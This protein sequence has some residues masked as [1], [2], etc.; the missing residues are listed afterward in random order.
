MP[1]KKVGPTD[2][3][4][5]PTI[6]W[7]PGFCAVEGSD[8]G[9]YAIPDTSPKKISLPTPSK[10]RV[11]VF[12]ASSQI[13]VPEE[14]KLKAAK[15]IPLSKSARKRL[16]KLGDEWAGEGTNLENGFEI[17]KKKPFFGKAEYH[18]G[19]QL[20]SNKRE[21]IAS[22]NKETLDDA[23]KAV[24]IYYD[25][26]AIK[27]QLEAQE[28]RDTDSIT[29]E[30]IKVWIG[31]LMHK[32]V[33][34]ER[35]ISPGLKSDYGEESDQEIIQIIAPLVLIRF[36]GRQNFIMTKK[37][38]EELRED[39][40]RANF[41]PI[42]LNYACDLRRGTSNHDFFFDEEGKIQN[43][44]KLREMFAA[45]VTMQ[46][47]VA[48]SN[49][50]GCVIEE[51]AEFFAGLGERTIQQLKEIFYEVAL[52]SISQFHEPEKK[53]GLIV[54]KSSVAKQQEEA[55]KMD[56]QK[57]VLVV[58]NDCDSPQKF[59]YSAVAQ[60]TMEEFDTGIGERFSN[61]ETSKAGDLLLK[62][63]MMRALIRPGK[64]M[65]SIEN[66]S[67]EIEFADISKVNIPPHRRTRMS[68]PTTSPTPSARN[69]LG[70]FEEEHDVLETKAMPQARDIAYLSA[71]D[72]TGQPG[73]NSASSIYD[74]PSYESKPRRPVVSATNKQG[75]SLYE[76]ASSGPASKPSSWQTEKSSHPS[77]DIILTKYSQV[78]QSRREHIS[79]FATKHGNRFVAIDSLNPTSEEAIKTFADIIAYAAF[80]VFGK[81]SKSKALE[82]FNT[83]RIQGGFTNIFTDNFYSDK[84]YNIEVKT[85]PLT[86]E[87][88]FSSTCQKYAKQCGLFNHDNL[89]NLEGC[90]LGSFPE[91]AEGIFRSMDDTAENTAAVRTRLLKKMK[92]AQPLISQDKSKSH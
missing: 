55:L 89:K 16:E 39:D 60:T 78:Q 6:A 35:K 61:R 26:E 12:A 87:Q 68:E 80:V 58:S 53:L 62:M 50:E 24:C 85:G 67:P 49:S 79:M 81:D 92:E 57:S 11:T 23:R 75:N 29:D 2:K 9:N 8:E 27:K 32:K 88:I 4:N 70:N 37:G 47:K 72:N 33:S 1:P 84:E 48:Y 42:Y 19:P 38:L 30:E 74:E 54:L 63:P 43:E 18:F 34:D 20:K 66:G 71:Y 15:F 22:S 65:D 45:A 17:Y 44:E 86:D 31:L 51:P 36:K 40:L 76:L 21:V 56:N 69:V 83:A 3:K 7:N 46:L 5:K 73:L 41:R 59:T 77:S 13:I 25:K 28:Y 91:E 90:S 52:D 82:C 10:E 64:I 14:E